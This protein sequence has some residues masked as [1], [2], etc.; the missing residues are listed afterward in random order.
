[1][2]SHSG[3][4]R[5][6]VVEL[7]V[8]SWQADGINVRV[9]EVDVSVNVEDGE[10]VVQPGEAHLGVLQDPGDGVLLVLVNFGGIE[11][12]GV[13]LSDSDLQQICLLDVLQLVSG[14]QDLPGGN[15]VVV[16]EVSGDDGA[17]SNEVVVLVKED[18]V[19]WELPGRALT[20]GEAGDGARVVPG[21][22]L[23]SCVLRGLSASL[24]PGEV[25]AIAGQ[26]PGMG[27]SRVVR[28]EVVRL[29]VV[30][31]CLR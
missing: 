23:L 12:C 26:V 2:A 30:G 28:R 16:V 24:H 1:V 31:G 6:Q 22:A 9:V 17:C 8:A 4:V 5:E 25:L 18:A 14:C 29:E 10:V 20:V 19:P 3:P 11:T 13:P 15:V 7:V 27:A 21:A